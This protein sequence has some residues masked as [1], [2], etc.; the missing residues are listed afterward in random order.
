MQPTSSGFEVSLAGISSMS[1]AL[2]SKVPMSLQ[3]QLLHAGSRHSA[4]P[5]IW[6]HYTPADG[7]VNGTKV[8][9]GMAPGGTAF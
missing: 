3:V 2:A 6:C 7:F 9:T 8:G 4:D 1:S 5:L